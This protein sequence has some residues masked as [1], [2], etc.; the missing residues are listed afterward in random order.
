MRL[1]LVM[2]GTALFLVGLSSTVE[3]LCQPKCKAATYTTTKPHLN[4]NGNAYKF[5]TP[6]RRY[7]IYNEADGFY[8]S[9]ASSTI[10]Y[11]KLLG[12]YSCAHPCYSNGGIE[13]MALTCDGYTLE[14]TEYDWTCY[15][16]CV[17]SF[18]SP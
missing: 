7:W 18:P 17:N 1:S 6:C 5:Q 4:V 2:L 12:A 8:T 11:Q 13:A 9:T 10:K 15:D 16:D 3:G 14:E